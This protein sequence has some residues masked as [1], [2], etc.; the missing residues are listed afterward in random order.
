L[1]PNVTGS[2]WDAVR[3]ADGRRHLVLEGAALERLEQLLDVG[4]QDVGARASCTLRQVSS[5]SDDVMP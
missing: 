3:T 2:A 5:T 4:D 1:S